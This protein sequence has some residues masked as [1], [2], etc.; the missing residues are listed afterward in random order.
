MTTGRPIIG[1]QIRG[2]SIEGVTQVTQ[3]V[4]T[5]ID[6]LRITGPRVLLESGLAS[7]TLVCFGLVCE[8]VIENEDDG[9]RTRNLR[10]DRP[11]L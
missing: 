3:P 11:V 1:A 4:E 8:M 6:V 7:L 2:D 9:A 10:R 5:K